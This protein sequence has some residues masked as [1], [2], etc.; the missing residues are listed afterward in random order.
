ML[1]SRI[2]TENEITYISPF[3]EDEYL[4]EYEYI[5][6]E[7]KYE[8]YKAIREKISIAL[9]KKLLTDFS[10]NEY[11]GIYKLEKDELVDIYVDSIYEC[12]FYNCKDSCVDFSF[13]IFYA[14]DDVAGLLM[15]ENIFYNANLSFSYSHFNGFDLS[16][17]DC[18]FFNSKI[19]FIYSEF[20]CQDIRFDRA[21]FK[22]EEN[23]IVFYG[24]SVGDTGELVFNDMEL[25]NGSIELNNISYGNKKLSFIEMDCE[26][27][28]VYFIDS[29]FPEIP[30]EFIDSK[31]NNILLYKINSN[32]LINLKVAS[33][34]NIVIQECVVRDCALLGNKGH[35]NYTNYCLKDTTIAAE[36]KNARQKKHGYRID[37][38]ILL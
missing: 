33:A 17:A 27:G 13:C 35:K 12:F 10:M 38:S 19:E 14:S 36:P 15:D 2:Y 5:C 26:T 9:H 32:G 11:R 7:E 28:N 21:A 29:E 30:I 18:A 1:S 34:N 31:L 23:G 8:I 6:E 25:H 22:G 16:L 4:S 20:G 3:I 24:T 37:H